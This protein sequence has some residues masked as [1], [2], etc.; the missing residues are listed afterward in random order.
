MP[1]KGEAGGSKY[2]S[3]QISHF[4][5]VAARTNF[6][7]PIAKRLKI[8]SQSNTLRIAMSKN[9]ATKRN[10]DKTVP[11]ICLWQRFLQVRLFAHAR[12]HHNAGS[13]LRVFIQRN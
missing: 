6:L 12:I 11:W 2:L 1:Q 8:S 10:P 3:W 9:F 4:Q 13:F 5:F 7:S